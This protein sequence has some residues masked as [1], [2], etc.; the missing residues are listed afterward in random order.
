MNDDDI[1]TLLDNALSGFLKNKGTADDSVDKNGR[2]VT[3]HKYVEDVRKVG[4]ADKEEGSTV[5]S[6]ET[7]D[8]ES[9]VPG[10]T[11]A[12]SK[13]LQFDPLGGRKKQVK[14]GNASRSCEYQ[15]KKQDD[16]VAGFAGH[17][18]AQEKDQLA[19]LMQNLLGKNEADIDIGDASPMMD[20]LDALMKQQSSI[21]Q[22]RGQQEPGT[23]GTDQED[24]F[25]LP[26]QFLDGIMKQLVSKDVLYQPMKD[27]CEKYPSWLEKEKGTLDSDDYRKYHDQYTIISKMC[28]L[29]ETDPE[30]FGMIMHLLQE[31]QQL[32][33]PPSE[34]MKE[35]AP[36]FHH[37]S[38]VP[39]PEDCSIQ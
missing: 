12:T 36:D 34:I 38:A 31:M 22:Q 2:N 19:A 24:D 1:D 4:A 3:S 9:N 35:L 33:E 27:I 25:G 32:G 18:E 11:I 26:T 15:R 14:C 23:S 20:T 29:Y 13:G 10:P 39:S 16:R 28:K 30:N 37:L 21:S 8:T 7:K 5:F 17:R 6:F